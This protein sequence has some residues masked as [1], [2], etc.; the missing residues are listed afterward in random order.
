MTLPRP[1]WRDMTTRASFPKA[2]P[3]GWIAVLPN[4]ER[5]NSHGPHLPRE[6]STR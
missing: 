4:R 6:A 1:F 3:Q 2:T 5:S